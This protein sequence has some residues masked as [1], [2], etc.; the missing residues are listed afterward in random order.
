[1]DQASKKPGWIRSAADYAAM[2][3]LAAMTLLVFASVVLRYCFAISFRWSDELTRYIFIYIVFLG[4]AIAYRHG[5]HVV[6]EIVTRFIPD[7]LRRW[8]A[9]PV[10]AIIGCMMLILGITGVWLTFGRMGQALTPGLQIPRAYMHAAL[11]IG[12]F[13]LLIEIAIKLRQ[14]LRVARKSG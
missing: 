12:V 3:G 10:H 5:D 2:L 4:I 6:I 9:V 13:F 7:R 8:L 1:M 11:P 14:S